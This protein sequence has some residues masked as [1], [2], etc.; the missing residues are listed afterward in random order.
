MKK[1]GEEGSRSARVPNFPDAWNFDEVLFSFA[2]SAYDYLWARGIT[3]DG[4]HIRQEQ[5][6]RLPR[7]EQEKVKAARNTLLRVRI[8]R[9][10]VTK[11]DC[12]QAVTNAVELV[13][14]ARRLMPLDELASLGGQTLRWRSEGGKATHREKRE[15]HSIYLNYDAELRQKNRNLTPWARA[16]LIAE[17]IKSERG[18]EVHRRTVYRQIRPSQ[19]S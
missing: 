4:F 12:K 7:A 1:R 10:Y 17:R 11:G 19:E 16:G 2:A 8:I 5:I 6:A 3:L 18:I 14:N 15:L 9:D 13:A